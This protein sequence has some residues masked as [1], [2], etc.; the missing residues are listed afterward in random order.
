[1]TV[2]FLIT[3]AVL[4]LSTYT[5][6]IEFRLFVKSGYYPTNPILYYLNYWLIK[7]LIFILLFLI[8]DYITKEVKY[9]G[10][11]INSL[12]ST[13]PFLFFLLLP[14]LVIKGISKRI[15]NSP[16]IYI[17]LLN[18]PIIFLIAAIYILYH[19]EFN[20]AL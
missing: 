16:T 19:F 10:H 17:F 12:F 3:I 6:I 11:F 8:S 4:L 20:F 15:F 5:Q 18:L 2:L 13:F 7:I 14:F 9:L 1:M